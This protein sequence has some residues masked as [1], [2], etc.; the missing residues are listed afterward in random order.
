M[1]SQTSSDEELDHLLSRISRTQ[2]VDPAVADD[3]DV[4]AALKE[5]QRS[6]ESGLPASSGSSRAASRRTPRRRR[7]RRRR[8]VTAGLAVAVA[9][10]ASLVGVESFGGGGGAGLSLPLAVS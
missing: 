8:W 4:R 5:V 6:I 3:E 7:A 9:G 2:P 1:E 10:V